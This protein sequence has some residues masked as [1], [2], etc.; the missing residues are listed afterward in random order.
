LRR[1]CPPALLLSILYVFQAGCPAGSLCLASEPPDEPT[2][3]KRRQA[4]VELLAKEISDKRVL[5]AIARVPRHHFVPASQLHQ[6]YENHPLSIGLEQTISQPYIVAYMTQ[7]LRLTG[8]EKILEVG[9]GSGY[10][11]AVLALTSRE[12]Y[13]VEILPELSARAARVLRQT[14]IRNVHL[15]VGDGFDGWPEQAPFDGIMV[16]AAPERVPAPLVKQLKE[17]GRLVIP[18]GADWDQHL[19][20]YVKRQDRLVEVDS[21][22]V[23]FVPMTGKALR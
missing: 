12:V 22:P 11:A 4:L 19:K 14:G 9:T 8:G 15:K 6:A 16:T 20:T 18:L 2:Q 1:S 13:S 3:T 21:L 17:G 7:A 23:R 10:Q 5:E